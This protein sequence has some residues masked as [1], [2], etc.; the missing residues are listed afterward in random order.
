MTT[1]RYVKVIHQII[2]TYPNLAA[3]FSHALSIERESIEWK[4]VL[5]NDLTGGER[6]A[7]AWC[8]ALWADEVNPKFDPFKLSYSM[9]ERLRR[10]VVRAVAIWLQVPEIVKWDSHDVPPSEHPKKRDGDR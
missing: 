10:A 1:S 7:V 6:T 2:K 9:D 5:R 4:M 8:M 3:K